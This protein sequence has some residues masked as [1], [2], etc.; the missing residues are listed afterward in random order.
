VAFM[1]RCKE[2]QVDTSSAA[3]AYNSLNSGFHCLFVI[4]IVVSGQ[5]ALVA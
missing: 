1:L 5:S 4:H 2:D 3:G